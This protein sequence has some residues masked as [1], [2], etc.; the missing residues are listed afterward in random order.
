MTSGLCPL[1]WLP[2]PSA[3]WR[4]ELR[5]WAND[6]NRDAAALGR[7]ANVRLDFVGVGMVDTVA[8]RAAEDPA[9]SP[10]GEPLRLAILGTSTLTHLHSSIRVAGLRR[11][12]QIYTYETDFGQHRQAI[13]DSQS[14]LKAFEPQAVLFAFD[15]WTVTAGVHPGLGADE[16]DGLLSMQQRHLRDLW[17]QA[18]RQC[19]GPI[20]QQ[21]VMPAFGPVLGNNEHRLA[22]SRADFIRRLNAWL[23]EVADDAGI[24]LLSL[25]QRISLD[26]LK[27]WHD[28]ALW[29][30]SKQEVSPSAAPMYGDLVARLLGALW[31]HSA[32]CLVLDLDNTLWGGVVGDDGLEGLVLGQGSAAGE[33]FVA[34]QEYARDLARRGVIL[35][36]CS[37]NE[38]ANALEAFERH[39]E[40][41]LRRN[42]I[43]C[44]VANWNDKASNLRHIAKSLNIGL[45]ALVFLDDNPAERALVRG[46]LPMVAVPE[47]GEDPAFYPQML[48]DAGYFEAVRLTA[49]DRR[50]TEDYRANQLRASAQFSATDM[51]SYL[52]DLNM[53]LVWRRFDRV[54]LARTTQ[55]INKTNQFN[56]T[57]RRY[58]EEEVAAVIESPDVVGLQMRL[59]DRFGDNGIICVVIARKEGEDLR[60]DNWLMSCR[61]LGRRVEEAALAV[62]LQAART[63]GGRRLIGEYRPTAKN[64]MV[65]DHYARLGFTSTEVDALGGSLSVLDLDT[66]IVPTPAIRIEEGR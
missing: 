18:R 38:E 59:L 9:F 42:D 34:I 66:A 15:A 28:V 65:R 48:A 57:T 49:E 60:I 24:D 23:R 50:R 17:S 39:P 7:L 19:R 29:H 63:M 33:A 10:A 30:R 51:E 20:L 45:D 21:T 61:V 16:V 43:S 62:L 13:A 3:Q 47:V 5:A 58:T 56:L 26:G 1:E 54:G 31:G 25:D 32:K 8:R 44:F 11:G 37:K 4:T 6:S 27:A 2:E 64:G 46:E 55:L 41:I 53:T 22:G 52:R 35:A 40:M 14:D 12:L 36:V